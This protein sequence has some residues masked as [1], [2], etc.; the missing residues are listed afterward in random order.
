MSSSTTDWTRRAFLGAAGAGLAIT[1][2]GRRAAAQQ[3][4]AAPARAGARPVSI[5][6]GNGL[7]ATTMTRDMLKNGA[8]PLDAIVEGV[9][10]IEDDPADNSV[11]YGGLPNEEGVVELDAGAARQHERQ[12]GGGGGQAEGGREGGFH[13]GLWMVGAEGRTGARL[14]PRRGNLGKARGVRAARSVVRTAIAGG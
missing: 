5:A 1:A 13:C 9:K 6:S 2:I 11:G 3:Q 14:P 8:D 12:H 4:P 10:I 7:R